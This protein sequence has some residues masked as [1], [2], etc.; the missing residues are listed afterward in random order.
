MAEVK[1]KSST[2]EALRERLRKMQAKLGELEAKEKQKARA[3]ED[4]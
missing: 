3:A 4:W 1:N 2:A